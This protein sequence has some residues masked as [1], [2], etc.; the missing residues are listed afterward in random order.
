MHLIKNNKLTADLKSEKCLQ[1]R[2]LKV[3]KMWVEVEGEG[4]KELLRNSPTP[5]RC[6]F[7][8]VGLLNANDDVDNK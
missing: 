3:Q 7:L 5:N 2:K 1:E 6:G 8:S 4:I